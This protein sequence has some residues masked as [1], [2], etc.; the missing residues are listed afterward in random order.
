M[1][2]ADIRPL[3]LRIPFQTGG[4]AWGVSGQDWN[5]LDFVL[6]RVELEDGAVGW[7]DAFGYNCRA[8]VH[9]AGVSCSGDR[10]RSICSPG[11]G[12]FSSSM[13]GI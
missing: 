10:P 5:F 12:R 1:K 2:I 8:A 9:A 6:V 3:S 13:Q 11:S 7:G 4:K